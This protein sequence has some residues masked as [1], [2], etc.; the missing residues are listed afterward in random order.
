MLTRHPI[1]FLNVLMKP[2][3]NAITLCFL[4]INL[5]GDALSQDKSGSAAA[6]LS[7]L[8]TPL[9]LNTLC[10]GF[11]YPMVRFGTA[12]QGAE[13][14]PLGMAAFF[15]NGSSKELQ[16]WL[17]SASGATQKDQWYFV[18]LPADYSRHPWLKELAYAGPGKRAANSAGNDSMSFLNWLAFSCLGDAE[19]QKILQMTNIVL[20]PEP[21]NAFERQNKIP[22]VRDQVLEGVQRMRRVA[23]L[24]LLNSIG[25]HD[26]A[27]NFTTEE[28]EWKEPPLRFSQ[29]GWVTKGAK[30]PVALTKLH[31]PK[32]QAQALV[33]GGSSF[34][35][36][37]EV[38]TEVRGLAFH[39]NEPQLWLEVT[40][41]TLRDGSN[42]PDTNW[43]LEL[44]PKDLA[45]DPSYEGADSS[46]LP[47]LVHKTGVK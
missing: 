37:M 30:L 18:A 5:I 16:D 8:E 9:P 29:F 3:F 47:R 43:S 11:E 19:I 44:Q 10:A 42:N 21:P 31:I 26:R 38:H 14:I 27:Y 28:I 17:T 13:K 12:N 40:G 1:Y 24:S 39:R 32:E 22:G 15:L 4:G 6:A 46:R 2:V 41:V 33:H 25:A 35:F 20:N 34:N 36:I 7:K 23:K 45:I